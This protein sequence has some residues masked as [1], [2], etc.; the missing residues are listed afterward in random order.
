[1]GASTAAVSLSRFA[2]N[3]HH[4]QQTDQL[5]NR[6]DY[7]G[8]LISSAKLTDTLMESYDPR[9]NWTAPHF[10]KG[11]YMNSI[12]KYSVLALAVGLSTSTFALAHEDHNDH[13]SQPGCP[14][15]SN[16]VAPEID[17][18]DRSQRTLAARRDFDGRSLQAP[19]GLE[20]ILRRNRQ[21][22]PKAWNH[23]R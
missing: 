13:H 21:P 14:P 6:E 22:V 8:L 17:P 23:W 1:M 12:L 10:S 7:L 5:R 2:A 15:A 9:G 20:P 16:N 18:S 4:N 11:S 3:N 19:Q